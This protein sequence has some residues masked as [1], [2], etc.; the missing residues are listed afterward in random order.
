MDV[1]G[2]DQRMTPELFVELMRGFF[3]RGWVVGSS[4]G[5]AVLTED[6][7][8]EKVI[9]YSPSSVQKERMM[10]SDLFVLNQITLEL[11]SRPVNPRIKESACVPIFNLLLNNNEGTNCVIHTH[12]KFSNLLTQLLHDKNVFEI[13]NQEMIKGVVDGATGKN[14]KNT[15]I[16]QVPII[17]NAE[18][19]YMLLSCSMTFPEASDYDYVYF[20][21]NCTYRY[22]YDLENPLLSK[23]SL[24]IDGPFTFLA[25][26]LSL[27]GAH[28]SI[29]FLRSTGLNKNF[30]AVFVVACSL[31]LNSP[32]FFEFEVAP[33]MSWLHL[34][35]TDHLAP[36][37]MRLSQAYHFLRTVIMMATQTIGPVFTIS[38]ITCLTEYKLY[39][40]LQARR[41]L[42]ESQNRQKSVILLDELKETVSRAVA[43]FI[44]VKF[45][46][47]RSLPAFFDLYETLHG[48]ESFG[49]GMSILVRVSDFGVVLNSATNS[50]AYF[51]RRQWLENR[52][53]ER[54]LKKHVRSS[55]DEN[56][57]VAA[58]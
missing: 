22:D 46:L 53:K 16:L 35:T 52:L 54:I 8:W 33:C 2:Y 39:T 17:E 7:A 19:E 24:L 27:I 57:D 31:I 25:A 50:L 5:M 6:N 43:I 51:G 47:L 3:D 10:P 13:T 21:P 15:D 37:K 45:L 23:V 28:Y 26:V 20:L 40:S 58:I 12:S 18:Q 56:E 49:T 14:L 34:T 30:T 1:S 44:A 36:T 32:V 55:A 29:K 41:R 48:I 42:M 4:G 9:L 38:V 11:V